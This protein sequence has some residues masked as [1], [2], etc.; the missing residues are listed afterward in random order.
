MKTTFQTLLLAKDEKKRTAFCM[1]KRI[2][3]EKVILHIYVKQ[4]EVT[5]YVFIN[6]QY[7]S[8][9]ADN[10]KLWHDNQFAA[11][12]GESQRISKAVGL[13]LQLC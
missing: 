9:I 11:S 4:T 12:W 10:F 3:G 7:V 6:D 2:Q 8:D 1:Y 13:P 5:L